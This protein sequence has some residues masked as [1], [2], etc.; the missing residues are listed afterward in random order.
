M[1]PLKLT[2]S[3]F[4]PYADVQTIDFT[5]LKDKNIFLITGPTGAGKTTVFD[6]ISYALFGEASGSSRDRDSLRSDFAHIDLYTYVELEFQLKGKKYKV[7]RYPQQE[8]KKSR[9]DGFITKSAEAFLELPN[10]DSVSKINNVDEKINEILGINKNQFKQIVMLPQGEFRKLLE[11]DSSERELIFR[12]IFGTEAF[13]SIQRILDEHKKSLYKGISNIKIKRDTYI[14]NIE[15]GDEELLVKLINAEDLNII[16]I[17]SKVNEIINNDLLEQEK[18]NNEINLLKLDS[19]NLQKKIIEGEEINKKI[20][21]K[22]EIYKEYSLHIKKALEY[23]KKQ[24]ILNKGRKSLE[25]KIVEDSLNDRQNNLKEKQSQYCSAENKLKQTENNIIIY[26][27]KLEIEESREEERKRISDE[28]TTL[29]NFIHRVKTYEE[30]KVSIVELKKNL[31]NKEEIMKKNKKLVS[32]N[33]IKLEKA[34]SNLIQLQKSQ[35]ELEKID[36]IISENKLVYD[37]MRAFYSYITDYEK[38]LAKHNSCRDSYNK[39]EIEYNDFKIKYEAME[40][41][42]RKG[43]AGILA[44]DLKEGKECPVCGSIHHPKLANLI[45]GVP[46]EEELKETKAQY[47]NL[48]KK[49]DEMLKEL[50]DL[51]GVIKSNKDIIVKQKNKLNPYLNY[52]LNNIEYSDILNYVISKGKEINLKLKNL[53]EQRDSLK[54]D[55]KNITVLEETIL[56]LQKEIVEKERSIENAEGEFTL[57]YGKVRSEEEL[58]IS[59]ENEIPVEIRSTSMLLLK[60]RECEEKFMH[61]QEAYKSAQSSY[62]KALEDYA[63]SKADKEAKE[64]N[65]EETI[66]EIKIWE[67]QLINKIKE[68]GF[69]DYNQYSQLKMDE[70]DIKN[71]ESDIQ[72]HYQNLKSLRDRYEKAVKDTEGLNIISI[73]ELKVTLEELALNETSLMKKNNHIFARLNNN[74]RVLKEVEDLNEIIK[75]EEKKYST[76]GELAKIANGDNAERITFE[77]YVLAAY[78]DEIIDAANVRLRKMAAGRFILRRKEEKGKGRKQEGLELEVFD[79]YTG[80][81]RHVKTLSG[82]ESFKAS[83]SLALGLADVVQSYAGGISLDTMFVDEGFGTLDPESLDNAIQTLIDLQK[84]GRL[85]GIISHVPE[86]KERI[87]SRLE[88]STTKEGSRTRFVL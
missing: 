20:Y 72:L 55:I 60:I 67:K 7:T 16:E 87:D 44:I 58:L 46:T 4:G 75:D 57:Q 71:L 3:A 30:K 50:S 77:R 2:M 26:K 85:V 17:I 40:D 38:F 43:Q 64:K 78:F 10:G 9:G 61:L 86:L 82:G 81:A 80:K 63:S 76:I 5:V 23:E 35:T 6:A 88:V 69:E 59:I 19:S 51:N 29:K 37:E 11:S 49:R 36:K 41:N 54:E 32:D 39:F 34:N 13:E 28:I 66:E 48:M 70:W 52:E 33:R 27:Q 21:D 47:D 45:D 84:G 79:N 8:H 65:L 73:D 1:R 15:C 25:V 62:N 68:Y 31:E 42:F 74:K 22:E 53:N 12:K 56:N 24:D 14:K 83:L 18:V